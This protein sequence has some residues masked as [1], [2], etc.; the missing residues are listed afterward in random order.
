[1]N[2]RSSHAHERF[3]SKVEVKETIKCWLWKGVSD[4]NGYGQFRFEGK[5]IRAPRVAFYLRTGEWPD[6][7]CHTCDNPTCCNPD[8]IFSGT[9][10][11]NMMDMMAKGRHK[12]DRGEKHGG[13]VLTDA[14]VVGIRNEYKEGSLSMSQLAKKY[15]C[16]FSTIQR[17]I[18]RKNWTHLP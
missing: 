1:M 7:A 12:T 15:G 13:A 16:S 9:R 2:N 18:S 3:W 10:K 14:L 8:H 6:N 4:S 11:D 17:V 5:T